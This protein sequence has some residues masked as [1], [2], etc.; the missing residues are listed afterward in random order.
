VTNITAVQIVQP[1]FPIS[2]K[3]QAK[4]KKIRYGPYTLPSTAT[5]NLQSMLS[6]ESGMI[7]TYKTKQTLPCNDCTLLYASG[8]LEYANGSQANTDTGSW[9]H[10][11]VLINSGKGRTSAACSSSKVGSMGGDPFVSFGNERD[12]VPFTDDNGVFNTGY[13]I[14]P[15]DTLTLYN[16]LMNMDTF[17]KEV[18]LTV[19]YEYLEGRQEG[20]NYTKAVWVSIGPSCS[21]TKGNGFGGANSP[22]NSKGEPKAADSFAVQSTNWTAPWAASMIGTGETFPLLSMHMPP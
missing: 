3:K 12:A 1:V 2:I 6:D 17:E 21:D 18:Y 14:H 22:V 8:S 16:E 5:K 9:L 11:T 19:N 4:A 15:T 10:H 20:W 7:D 13:Y